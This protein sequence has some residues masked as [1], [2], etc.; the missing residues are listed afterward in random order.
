MTRFTTL[1]LTLVA[2][3]MGCQTAQIP[4]EEYSQLATPEETFDFVKT[5]V[6]RD[7]IDAFYYCL[8]DY[9]QKQVSIDQLGL[10]WA[11]AGNFFGLVAQV[12]IQ[13][14]EIPAPDFPQRTDLAK[15]SVKLKNLEAAFL[16]L[17]E[18][19]KWKIA[20]P[21]HYGTPDIS[22][23]PTRKQLPWRTMARGYQTQNLEDW[24][25]EQY[26]KIKN[27]KA[28]LPPKRIPWRRDQRERYR[29]AQ[30]YMSEKSK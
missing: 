13:E 2:L 27:K 25:R 17:K 26:K 14:V 22:Q 21:Q 15:V 8:A 30:S 5:A 18:Q 23:L 29:T 9:I 4:Q 16:L 6:K 10:A 28:K 20:N 11:L 19:G 12:E 3:A 1:L 24:D 7:D